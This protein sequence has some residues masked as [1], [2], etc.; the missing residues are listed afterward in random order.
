MLRSAR[1]AKIL[2]LIS[3]KEIE[4]QEELIS[5]LSQLGYDVTQATVSRDI[6]DLKISKILTPRGT[7]KYVL[8]Q[9]PEGTNVRFKSA[10]SESIT[11]ID[12]AMNQI[13]I[14]TYPGM[15][16]AIA[17]AI[18]GIEDESVL[19]CV[20][21]DDAIIVITRDIESAERVGADMRRLIRENN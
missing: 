19:G 1:H 8:P 6:R 18:D 2:E 5:L 10:L 7:Y 16:Q 3:H 15:A 20:A 14:K 13:I 17:A 21:G 9:K 4:T 12:W 11:K